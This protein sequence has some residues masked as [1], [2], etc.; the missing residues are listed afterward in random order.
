MLGHSSSR[1]VGSAFG[2]IVSCLGQ[3]RSA[4]GRVK[5]GIDSLMMPIAQVAVGFRY[6]FALEFLA[7]AYDG[8]GYVGQTGKIARQL[9][10]MS[11]A[12][13]L[14][15]GKIPHIAHNGACFQCPNAPAPVSAALRGQPVRGRVK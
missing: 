5:H 13:I 2:G 12:P 3:D 4:T 11:P 1:T 7:A 6:A 8:D 14:V 9:F 10:L 15:I